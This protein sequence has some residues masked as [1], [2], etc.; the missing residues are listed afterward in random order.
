MLL[1]GAALGRVLAAAERT[2][3]LPLRFRASRHEQPHDGA[4]DRQ[5]EAGREARLLPVALAVGQ[6]GGDDRGDQP[7]V[8]QPQRGRADE[9]EEDHVPRYAFMTSGLVRSASEASLM[10]TLPVSST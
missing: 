3:R 5:D 4:D 10:T 8:E 7:Q 9:S 2:D 6:V 1:G